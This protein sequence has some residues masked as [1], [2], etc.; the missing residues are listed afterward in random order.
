MVISCI[1]LVSCS[2]EECQHD[3]TE[4]VVAATCTTGGY[5]E[6]KCSKCGDTYKDNEVAA[7]GHDLTDWA[8]QTAATCT[9]AQV[10]ERHCQR[11]GCEHSETQDG[12]TGALGHLMKWTVTKEATCTE[13]GLKNGA[14]ERCDYTEQDQTIDK[15]GHHYVEVSDDEKAKA[16]TCTED[17]LKVEICDRAGCGNRKE[18]PLLALG[19]EDDGTKEVVVAPT[20]TEQGYTIR[21]C[22]RCNTD[23]NDNLEN[24]LGHDMEK[25][26]T[27]D[28]T[29]VND[30]Y[31]LWSCKRD[32]CEFT[33]KKEEEPKLDHAFN[34][35]G[36][37]TN[38]CGKTI[39]DKI[40]WVNTKYSVTY[41]E[42][43]DR[44]TMDGGDPGKDQIQQK[45]KIPAELF[46]KMKGEGKAQFS[47]TMY[48][49][50][51]TTPQLGLNFNPEGAQSDWKYSGNNVESYTSG[52]ITITD[53]MLTDGFEFWTLYC[54]LTQRDPAWGA[55]AKC[56]GF[57]MD[58][59]F[60]KPFDIND[61]SMWLSS[62][63][64]ST[65]YSEEKD[66]WV[67]NDANPGAGAVQKSVTILADVFKA[68]PTAASFRIKMYNQGA[69]TQKPQFGIHDGA[70]WTYAHAIDNPLVVEI[71][72]TDDMRANGFTFTALYVDNE[73]QAPGKWG[74][75]EIVTGFDLD[76]EFIKAFDINDKTMWLTSGFAS[77]TYSA[78]KGMWV[79]NDAN[80]GAGA[81]Q[82]S[83]TI[84]ADVFKAMPTAASF[85]IKM[86][87]QGATTQKPQFGIHDGAKW[88]YA[89]AIDNPLVVEIVI[90][91]DMRANG[92]T[93][94]ALYVDNNQQDPA[95]GGTEIVT[96]FDL[97][98]EFN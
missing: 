57:D 9:T 43:K 51:G 65:T 20:C 12:E 83:V 39:N 73:Q 74:G 2:I 98:I 29:C 60:I 85:R 26:R 36:E 35:K 87:N 82:K 91:D 42:A 77:T 72:I 53:E 48:K 56:T 81:V 32:G 71:V 13:N 84:L 6:H 92:F 66:M 27:V 93:F 96:G 70:K 40:T 58:V 25:T 86:Y 17:G 49:W 89:H 69:T 15:L 67:I 38:G 33:E 4:S 11:T 46:A 24:A 76:I 44:L 97:T 90:T 34:D 63:F 95:W 52:I 23:Y 55:T 18:T 41:N 16:A 62:G 78:E 5:T 3:Y 94:T 10:M 75:T 14:C 45:V 61:K 31:E 79:I 8:E 30:G 64:A 50:N 54:D 80:P 1:G 47:V 22:S 21:H 28:V 88:T 68:M 7:L 59:D 37:C 19:H